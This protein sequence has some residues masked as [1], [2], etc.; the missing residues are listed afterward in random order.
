M[1]HCQYEDLGGGAY[2]IHFLWD[3]TDPEQLAERESKSMA[4]DQLMRFQLD[5]DIG[6]GIFE[7][8]LGGQGYRRYPNWAVMDM[9]AFT[10]DKTPSIACLPTAKESINDAGRQHRR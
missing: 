3:S 1:A 4:L 8:L 2:F 10:Q 6:L 5:G 7:L 9:S